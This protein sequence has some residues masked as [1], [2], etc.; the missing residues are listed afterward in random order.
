MLI[1]TTQKLKDRYD[2]LTDLI[3]KPE[4]IADNKEWKKLVKE[5]SSL[6]EIVNSH[7]E[8]EKALQDKKGMEET[9]ATETDAEMNKF[10]EDELYHL[11][12]KILEMEEEIKILLLPKFR[13]DFL[14]L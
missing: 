9:I 12:G 1:E 5:R 3:I 14:F 2:E 8:Y 7:M 6:E 10:F 11:N 4:V 13:R